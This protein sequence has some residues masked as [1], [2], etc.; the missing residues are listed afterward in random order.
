MK[1]CFFVLFL[2]ISMCFGSICKDTIDCKEVVKVFSNLMDEKECIEIA[3]K[4]CQASKDSLN[5]IISDNITVETIQKTQELYNTSF[6]NMQSSFNIFILAIG[7]F[8]SILAIINFKS[9][10]N[11]KKEIK[12]ELLKIKGFED[13]LDAIKKEA[14]E[15][16]ETQKRKVKSSTDNILRE[17]MEV[18]FFIAWEKI[19]TKKMTEHFTNLSEYFRMFTKHNVELN[20]YSDLFYF[21]TIESYADSYERMPH[22]YFLY[23]FEKLLQYC[24]SKNSE[25]H[26]KILERTWKK[27]C[28]RFGEQNVL[29]AVKKYKDFAEA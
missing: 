6:S 4:K 11:S 15:E 28:D 13:K 5:K 2:A 16:L 21:E 25:K 1:K 7:I 26:I 17:M 19:N 22:G 8:I 10:E 18:K 9:V 3:A 29:D 14:K 24:K 12:E 23:D 27:L 20:D